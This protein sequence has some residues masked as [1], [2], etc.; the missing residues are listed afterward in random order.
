MDEVTNSINESLKE[1]GK[2]GW[3]MDLRK[4]DALVAEKVMGWV[5]LERQEQL[6]GKTWNGELFTVEQFRSLYSMDI[7]WL[8]NGEL[9]LQSH[10]Y[11]STDIAAAWDIMAQMQATHEFSIEQK[12]SG[13]KAHF[14]AD[15]AGSES[16]P[17]AICLAALRAKG[18]DVSE[19][20]K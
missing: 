13:W 1:L 11:Y 14:D 15:W 18:I 4:L 20:E 17:L 8:V 2:N 5:R 12:G 6:E 9:S 10:P 3:H 16:A 19:W 7:A